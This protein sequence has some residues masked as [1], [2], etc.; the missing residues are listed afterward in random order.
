MKLWE[1]ETITNLLRIVFQANILLDQN[2]CL[3]FTELITDREVH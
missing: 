1:L 2:F 3:I